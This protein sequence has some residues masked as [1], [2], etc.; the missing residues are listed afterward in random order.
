[1]PFYGEF[2]VQLGVVRQ[3][4]LCA[5]LAQ[6]GNGRLRLG[7][8]AMAR[9]L[10]TA[11]QV[12]QARRCQRNRGQD[13]DDLRLGEIAVALGF[14]TTEQVEQLY[15]E[16]RKD[17]RRIGDVL[18]ELGA[19]TKDAHESYLRDFLHLELARRRRLDAS[20]AQMP[21]PALVAMHVALAR[22]LLP[23]FGLMDCKVADVRVSPRAAPGLAWSGRRRLSGGADV[24]VLLSVSEPTLARLAQDATGVDVPDSPQRALPVLAQLTETLSDLVCAKLPELGLVGEE[25][26]T[27]ADD[28]FQ[29]VA[30]V[31]GDGDLA[32][33]DLVHAAGGGISARSVLTLLT[34]PRD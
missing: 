2:L 7:E 9:E 22:R 17:W 28:G 10:L 6:Q 31:L 8:L 12:A 30:D 33:I 14:I 23:R 3:D 16:Q 32:Q 24:V 11:Q 26:Q 15:T 1:M 21:H 18:V 29:S 20:I 4:Q 27:L 19:L 13:L 5:A 25:T 34:L